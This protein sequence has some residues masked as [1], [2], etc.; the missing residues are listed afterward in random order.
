MNKSSLLYVGFVLFAIILYFGTDLKSE[1]QRDI[2]KSRS[3]IKQSISAQTLL[4]DAYHQLD[5]EQKVQV[6]ELK[7]LIDRAGDNEER[8]RLLEQL[9]GL[10]YKWGRFDVSGYYAEEIAL[11]RN[12]LEAWSLAGTTYAAGIRILKSERNRSYCAERA[13]SALEQAK[14]I[15]PSNPEIDLNL[16]LTYVYLPEETRPMQGIQMLLQLKTQHP[17]YAP[18]YRHLG[19]FAMQ[20][21]QYEKA[22]ER[23]KQAIALEGERGNVTCLLAEA[24]RALNQADSSSHYEQKCKN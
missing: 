5:D 13:R 8:M 23:L 11:E 9:A 3:I 12:T 20:T 18:V 1:D 14:L 2:E 17:E 7:I 22:V 19:T 15:D 24:Y 6:D 21:N 10:Y 16:A 4:R